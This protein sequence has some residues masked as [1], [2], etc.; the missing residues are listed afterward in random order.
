MPW[1]LGVDVDQ[2]AFACGGAGLLGF[3]VLLLF[4]AEQDSRYVQ[5]KSDQ[6]QVWYEYCLYISENVVYE[7]RVYGQL[8]TTITCRGFATDGM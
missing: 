4:V 7:L 5:D 1:C 8:W 6:L 2:R 3:V